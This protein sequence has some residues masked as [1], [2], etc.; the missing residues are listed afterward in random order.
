MLL[1]FKICN[2]DR[3]AAGQGGIR[4]PRAR[5]L[6]ADRLRAGAAGAADHGQPGAGR[7]AQGRQPLRSADRAWPDGGDRGYSRR[8]AFR[9]HRAR[10]ARARRIDRAGGRRA[11][12]GNRRQCARRGPD[13]PRGLRQRGGLGEPRHPDHR[14]HVAD[15]DRQPFSRHAGA[16]AA[17]AEGARARKRCSI[18][19]TSRARKAPSVRSR[20]RRPAGIIC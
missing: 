8:C 3:R 2:S 20:S 13:L 12:G 9:L 15:P 1:A 4:G 18:C 7:P 6:G 17:T 19:A 14:R 10:R 11:A 5:A 16:V